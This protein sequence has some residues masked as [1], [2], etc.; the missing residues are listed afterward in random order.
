M[1]TEYSSGV[2]VNGCEECVRFLLNLP[3]ADFSSYFLLGDLS[4]GFC[5]GA[6]LAQLLLHDDSSPVQIPFPSAPPYNIPIKINSGP[7]A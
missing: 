1:T 5:F 2:Y 7:R 3:L 4:A 6:A